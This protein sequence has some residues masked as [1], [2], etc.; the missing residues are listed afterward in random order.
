MH[1]YTYY[2]PVEM[3]G[4]RMTV[5]EVMALLKAAGWYE[6]G[7]TGS[8]RKFRHPTRPGFVIVAIHGGDIPT[9]T[10]RAIEKQS[11]VRLK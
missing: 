1:G 7:Q 8:H 9:G 6:A 2:S 3:A 4:E 10:L 5:K 11:G